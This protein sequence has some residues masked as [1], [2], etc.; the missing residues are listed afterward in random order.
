MFDATKW[1]K[2]KMFPV[3][4][5][6]FTW[7]HDT[8]HCQIHL[9]KVLIREQ[10]KRIWRTEVV[11]SGVTKLGCKQ[12]RN[13]TETI[14]GRQTAQLSVSWCPPADPS[15]MNSLLK[16]W[17]EVPDSWRTPTRRW[18]CREWRTHRSLSGTLEWN[19]KLCRTEASPPGDLAAVHPQSGN[20]D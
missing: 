9:C 12:P 17:S 19:R 15:S 14:T 4:L 20:R 6:L 3:Q 7:S 2:Y 1:L 16:C 5:E 11:T 18:T 8:A 10:R 13:R